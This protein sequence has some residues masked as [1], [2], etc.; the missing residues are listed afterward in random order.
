MNFQIRSSDFMINNINSDVAKR[1]AELRDVCGYTQEELAEE[2]GIDAEIYKRTYY[3]GEL[4][5]QA[6]YKET[7]KG[8]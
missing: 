7:Y 5:Y 8:R 6:K 1:I 4:Y 2:L 3:L